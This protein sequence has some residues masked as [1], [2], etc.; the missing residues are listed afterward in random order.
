MA[1]RTI[2]S[3]QDVIELEQKLDSLDQE[4]EATKD[5]L[6]GEKAR[7]LIN[8]IKKSGWYKGEVTDLTKNQYRK[9]IGKW[10]GKTILNKKG[11]VPWEYCFDQ[12]TEYGYKSDQDLKEAIERAGE[13]LAELSQMEKSRERLKGELEDLRENISPELI[14]KTINLSGQRTKVKELYVGTRKRGVIVRIPSEWRAVYTENGVEPSFVETPLASTRYAKDVPSMV[15]SV[16]EEELGKR[17]THKSNG[18]KKKNNNEGIFDSLFG[19]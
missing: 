18:G 6:K 5:E 19:S 10:P 4:I 8:L 3:V 7:R 14:S 1:R 11:H 9:L 13:T 16:Y 12:L 17:K 2:N 15:K